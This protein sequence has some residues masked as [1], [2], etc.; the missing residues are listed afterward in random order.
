[1][2][3]RRFDIKSEKTITSWDEGLPLGNGKL[4]C[5]IYGNNPLRLSLD[6]GDLWD[7]R[8][9]PATLEKAFNYE[10]LIRLSLSENEKEQAERTRLFERIYDEK[11]YPSKITA[12]RIELGF[13]SENVRSRLRIGTGIAE[14]RGEKWRAQ[15]FM[16]ATRFI[17][18]MK[19]TGDFTLN[20][21]VPVYISEGES[22]GGL[23]YPKAE[24]VHT[25]G[26]TYYI[27]NTKTDFSYG[28]V[29]LSVKKE[30]Y[31][32]LY[33]TVTHNGGN[34]EKDFISEAEAELSA[35]AAEEYE[36]LKKEHCA[37]WK[38]FWNKSEISL[39]DSALEKCYYRSWYLFGSCSRKGFYPMP[40][41]GVWTADNDKL[42]PWRGDYHHDTN[43]QLS[44]SAYLKANRLEEG[45]AFIDYLWKLKP[46]FEKFAK[47]FYGTQGL[48]IPGV[49]TIDGKPMGGW[50]QYSLSPTMS[51]WVAQ[52]FDEYYL[53][54]CDETFL[55][56]RAYPFF[57]EI[58]EAFLGILQ[59]RN[60][61]LY[62]PLST[63]PEIFDDTE[64]AY[65]EPNSNFD[66]SLLRYL[67]KTLIGYCRILGEEQSRYESA[68]S[69]LDEIAVIDGY[70]ALDSKRRLNES[71]RHFSHL[72]CLYPLHLIDYDTE[73]HKKLYKSALAEE[74]SLGT[75]MWVGFSFPM[76]AQ[77]YAMAL[78]GDGAYLKLR[79]FCDGF[80]AKNGFHLNGDFKNK[81]YSSFHYR[82]FT[83]EALF[84]FCDALQETLLQDHQGYIHVFPALSAAKKKKNVSFRRLRCSGGVLINATAE[85]GILT[86]VTISAKKEIEIKLKNTFVGEIETIYR[87]KNVNYLL[88]NDFLVFRLKK[89]KTKLRL[90]QALRGEKA[91]KDVAYRIKNQ[92]GGK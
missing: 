23:A 10:N 47:E 16:H 55:K 88:E 29:V 86:E 15:A 87:G 51:I 6:R 32:Y 21:R 75:D 57:K 43:T 28:I 83:L 63:S 92:S 27:Q 40:L 5:L 38:R 7:A 91:H 2:D 1:M 14:I 48:L 89:G 90:L 41:Q 8:P 44:Y 19:I 4:G 60:G 11:P 34:A 13:G 20:L 53:Y 77:I 67:F 80:V 36:A 79:R 56:Q 18:V 12:G 30:C 81:G 71:H 54:T 76:C 26:F 9:N 73:E 59:E 3:L 74:E 31:T 33:F 42:P 69:K 25:E 78:D 46:Q 66:L 22:N 39:G 64:K 50:A 82:P 58:G 62:L 49:F 84:G 17:G 37:W 35:V 61:K 70:I 85:K 72:M 52:S 45:E 24:I 68:L 65:L